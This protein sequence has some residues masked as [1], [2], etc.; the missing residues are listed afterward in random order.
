MR[1]ILGNATYTG[2]WVY[3]KYRHIATEDGMKIYDQPRDTWIEIPVP[4]IID[5]ETWERAQA[6]KKRRSGKAK[7][8]T[9]VL[10]LLQRPRRP[11]QSRLLCR[12]AGD[13]APR[14]GARGAQ[15]R[16]CRAL[17]SA[18]P[19]GQGGGHAQ[20]HQALPRMTEM[21]FI[22]PD[23]GHFCQEVKGPE[24]AQSILE[25]NWLEGP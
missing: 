7:R 15:H 20:W 22:H 4:Q 13:R 17:R 9:D 5:D 21:T 16:S 10:Y 19:G 24:M 2:S 3:G 6:R 8:N 23:V 1:H 12:H 25:I 14:V 18:G 11:G